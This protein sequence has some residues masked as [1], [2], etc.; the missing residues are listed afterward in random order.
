MKELLTKVFKMNKTERI[1][2]LCILGAKGITGELSSFESLEV[3]MI[4][5]IR[6]QIGE[7]KEIK[8]S[9]EVKP[10]KADHV[11]ETYYDASERK[12]IDNIKRMKSRREA[13]NT[14]LTGNSS[15]ELFRELSM[16]N[17]KL[18]IAESH[19]NGKFSKQIFPEEYYTRTI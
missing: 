4:Q 5:S 9:E 11:K 13:I 10:A 17:Y 2:R 12:L 6:E 1:E 14:S 8:P 15:A 7:I 3:M 19:V 18:K 16:I